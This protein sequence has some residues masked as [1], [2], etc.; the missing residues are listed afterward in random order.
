MVF[1]SPDDL[2]LQVKTYLFD[3][4]FLDFPLLGLQDNR[5]SEATQ[6]MEIIT[7]K[8]CHSIQEKFGNHSFT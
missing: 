8:E 5:I 3:W 6:T 7:P 1:Q 4:S 2:T